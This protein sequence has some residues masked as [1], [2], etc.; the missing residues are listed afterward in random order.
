MLITVFSTSNILGLN[1]EPVIAGGMLVLQALECCKR[2]VKD[3][4]RKEHQ[5]WVSSGAQR[6]CCTTVRGSNST[7]QQCN[8]LGSGRTGGG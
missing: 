2:A 7:G 3:L 8:L 4:E 5:G 1:P 6:G